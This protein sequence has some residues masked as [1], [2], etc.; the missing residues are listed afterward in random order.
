L[1]T[2]LWRKNLLIKRNLTDDN[3]GLGDS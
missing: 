2:Q 3:I 1:K